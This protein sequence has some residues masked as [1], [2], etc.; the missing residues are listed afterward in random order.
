MELKRGK[1]EYSICS[2]T[3]TTTSKE[4]NRARDSQLAESL[5]VKACKVERGKSAFLIHVTT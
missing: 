3:T 5:R 2:H 1:E 4:R